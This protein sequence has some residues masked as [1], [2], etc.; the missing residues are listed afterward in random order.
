MSVGAAAQRRG[1]GGT[2]CGQGDGREVPQHCRGA[3]HDKSEAR[4]R[5]AAQPAARNGTKDRGSW[6]RA[7]HQADVLQETG[8]IHGIHAQWQGCS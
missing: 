1:V 8:G 7:D 6:Q 4:E 2:P 3:G 5:L